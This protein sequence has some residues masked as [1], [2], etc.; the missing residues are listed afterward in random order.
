MLLAVADHPRTPDQSLLVARVTADLRFRALVSAGY[1]RL[2][3]RRRIAELDGRL[4]ADISEWTL[5]PPPPPSLWHQMG[6]DVQ[7]E[8]QA[9]LGVTRRLAARHRNATTTRL[10]G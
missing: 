7:A 9:E 8:L 4:R 6:G 1:N 3:R 2:G 10:W 5:P